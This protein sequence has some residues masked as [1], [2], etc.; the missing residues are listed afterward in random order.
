MT[1]IEKF[2]E[3]KEICPNFRNGKFKEDFA[4][5]VNMTEDEAAGT[6]YMASQNGVFSME[7]YDYRDHTAMITIPVEV[8][9]GILA[10]KVNAMKAF[11]AGRIRIDGNIHHLTTLLESLAVAMLLPKRKK[12]AEKTATEEKPKKRV[13]RKKAEEPAAAPA[14]AEKPVAEEKSDA[15]V[16]EAA[17]KPGRP[18][19]AK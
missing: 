18:K 12:K 7:P 6:F 19:K 16:K 11:E 5:Q 1:F 8:L 2:N 9:D 3:L 10:K 13:C 17:K 4:V 14:K 15:P